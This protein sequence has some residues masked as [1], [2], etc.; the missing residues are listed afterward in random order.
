[1]NHVNLWPQREKQAIGHLIKFIKRGGPFFTHLSLSTCNEDS[2]S[3]EETLGT[4]YVVSCEHVGQ[5]LKT[6]LIQTWVDKV[7]E[8]DRESV[9]RSC[10]EEETSAEKI[11]LRPY[12]WEHFV[13]LFKWGSSYF[14]S[15]NQ[16][17]EKRKRFIGYMFFVVSAT[18][19]NISEILCSVYL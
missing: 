18:N 12:L 5:I 6:G 16:A 11:V 3:K 9:V 2:Q 13:E 10:Q 17:S 8:R 4:M 14:I 15:K 7:G 1:M 19:K